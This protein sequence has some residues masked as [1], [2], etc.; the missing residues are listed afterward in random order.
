MPIHPPGRVRVA[1]GRV[2]EDVRQAA[3][4][5]VLVLGGH[6]GEDEA[7][8]VHAL[9]GVRV[10]AVVRMLFNIHYLLFT[11][12]ILFSIRNY[13]IHNNISPNP[14]LVT[15][16]F[17]LSGLFG[18]KKNHPLTPHSPRAPAPLLPPGG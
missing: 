13:I 16:L 8:G 14:S 4:P 3:P 2:E 6:V 7:G 10:E 17:G 1:G 18:R 11:I 15:G 12:I 9:R 5:H